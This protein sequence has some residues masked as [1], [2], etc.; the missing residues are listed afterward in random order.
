MTLM[1]KVLDRIKA[2]KSIKGVRGFLKVKEASSH[3]SQGFYIPV[4]ISGVGVQD[5]DCGLYVMV[6]CS[7]GIGDVAV[8]PCQILDTAKQVQD[9]E[10]NK[11]AANLASKDLSAIKNWSTISG[12]RNALAKYASTLT[13]NAKAR[14]LQE[15]AD[16]RIESVEKVP[17]ELI[18]TLAA[19]A[20]KSKHGVLD[21]DVDSDDD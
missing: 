13:G 1:G 2:G 17:G 5:G 15:L 4:V 18:S 12:R 6:K 9:Y 8:S 20:T 3:M 7:G 16:N 21:I 14:F 19:I 11:I 10:K